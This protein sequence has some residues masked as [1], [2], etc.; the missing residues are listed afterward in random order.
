MT[1]DSRLQFTEQEL[2]KLQQLRALVLAFQNMIANLDATE[3]N[4][5]Y[6]EQFN[7]LRTEA[8]T[9]LK[10]SSFDQNVPRAITANVLAERAHKV[11]TRLSGI[12]I[13]GVILALLGLG[14]NSI[15]LEDVIINSLGCLISTMGMLLV[16]GA[17]AVLAATGTRRQMTNL[18]DLY[19]R[20]DSLLQQIDQI[21]EMAIPDYASRPTSQVPQIPSAASLALDSLEKQRADWEQ[22]LKTLQE[23]Q[24]LLGPNL[25]VELMT[26]VN[27]VHQELDRIEYEMELLRK[28]VESL[29][30]TESKPEPAA[31]ATPPPAKTEITPEMVDRASSMTQ[32]MPPVVE[33]ENPGATSPVEETGDSGQTEGTVDDELP[34]KE[35]RPY[36]P[37]EA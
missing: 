25:P 26:T 9:I 16:V 27:F 20:C 3:Q 7:K 36:P 8:R 34:D 23:Q 28:R 24:Q 31:E 11:N 4:N 30:I 13:L 18:G 19:I 22:K 29:V 33:A 2:D 10:I 5:E 12:V 17:L 15:I 21:L 6:N 32:P 14:I 35:D 1:T 37:N